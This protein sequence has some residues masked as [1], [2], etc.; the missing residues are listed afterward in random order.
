MVEVCA[1]ES[2]E[3]PDRFRAFGNRAIT[4]RMKQKETESS[5]SFGRASGTRTHGL[6][7]PNVALYLL[8]YS[9]KCCGT[10]GMIL[11]RI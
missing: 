2:E 1:S 8:S 6:Y 11:F 3:N 4:P 9:P 10:M 5:V 7:V